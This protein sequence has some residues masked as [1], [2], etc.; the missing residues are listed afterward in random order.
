MN[1]QGKLLVG[2]NFT[3]AGGVLTGHLAQWDGTNWGTFNGTIVNGA[4][5][6]MTLFNGKP[7]IGGEFTLIN[8]NLARKVAIYDN[9]QWVDMSAGIDTSVGGVSALAVHNGELYAGGYFATTSGQPHAIAKWNGFSWVDLGSAGNPDSVSVI[10]SMGGDLYI[11][12]DFLRAANS[13]SPYLSKHACACYVNCDNST[14]SPILTGNDFTCFLNNYV[15]G[16][17]YANCD[18][19]TVQPVLT[20]NDFTCFLTKFANGCN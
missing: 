10:G 3:T 7:V 11:G 16:T 18:G 12:G 15:L 13:Y 17:S 8:G 1:Y 9:G 5:Y 14:G 2:G 6:A 4:V 19:S 20:A